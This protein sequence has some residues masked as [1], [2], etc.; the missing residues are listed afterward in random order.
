MYANIEGEY[1]SLWNAEFLA[2]WMLTNVTVVMA[3]VHSTAA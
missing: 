3:M 1:N 2:E